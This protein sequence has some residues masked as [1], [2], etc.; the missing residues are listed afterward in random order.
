[1]AAIDEIRRQIAESGLKA[2]TIEKRSGHAFGRGAFERIMKGKTVN[3]GIETVWAI[4][5]VLGLTVS[6]LI[7]EVKPP[8]EIPRG[9]CT[10]DDLRDCLDALGVVDIET[11]LKVAQRFSGST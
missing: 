5:G 6:E 8:A 9:P 2:P 11:V 7:G 4:A 10:W 3:P 1:M